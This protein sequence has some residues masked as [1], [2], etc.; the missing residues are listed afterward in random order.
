MNGSGNKAKRT[1][2][3][4]NAAGVWLLITALLFLFGTGSPAFAEKASA[5]AGAVAGE[6]APAEKPAQPVQR[7]YA[8]EPGQ[9]HVLRVGVLRVQ[10]HRHDLVH[11]VGQGHV[12]G[13]VVPVAPSM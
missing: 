8:L 3:W 13:Q 11:A 5:D 10:L 6:A 1:K 12:D 7:L 4:L 2:K 9:A